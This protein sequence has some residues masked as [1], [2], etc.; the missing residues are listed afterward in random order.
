MLSRILNITDVSPGDVL[1]CRS[2][3]SGTD[4]AEITRSK[5]A[6]AAICVRFGKVA[7][8]SGHRVKEIEI[9]KLLNEYDHIAVLRQPN[10]WSP[11]RIEKLQ[12]FV[13]D[14]IS[15]KTG[16]NCDGI[17]MFEQQKRIHEENLGGI[18]HDFFKKEKEKIDDL[19]ED[20]AGYFCSELVAAAYVAVGIIES[21]AAVVYEPSTLSPS[22]LAK[23]FTFGIFCGYLIPYAGYIIPEDDE[24]SSVP[25]LDEIF[26][27]PV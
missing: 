12:S 1:L 23:D 21:S 16:F 19:V 11:K 4:I 7:E 15:R 20:P 24:F 5:Y 18:L 8:A 25:L 13:D 27:K 22:D 17:R 2:N 14:A 9:Q 10:C 3:Y 26:E 6:H